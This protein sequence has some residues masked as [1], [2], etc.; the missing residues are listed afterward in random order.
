[1]RG[2]WEADIHSIAK[3]LMAPIDPKLL[4]DLRAEL[5]AG[6]Q[7]RKEDYKSVF[8]ELV[9]MFEDQRPI[10]NTNQPSTVKSSSPNEPALS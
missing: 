9:P 8:P 1:M 5:A 3:L 6:D 4:G 7:Y 10:G 2:R